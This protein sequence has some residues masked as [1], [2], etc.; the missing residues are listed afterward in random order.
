MARK[1]ELTWNKARSNW[2]RVYKGRQYYLKS[3]CRNKSDDEG[4]RRAL[5][6]WAAVKAHA[7]GNGPE[8][9]CD[10]EWIPNE[11]ELRL[12]EFLSVR[13]RAKQQGMNNGHAPD[14]ATTP[15]M[16][17]D[18]ERYGSKL[19][20]MRRT[21]TGDIEVSEFFRHYLDDRQKKVKSEQRPDGISV[22]Q[23]AQDR[24][25]LNDFEAY[26]KAH[27]R[28]MVSEID[29]YF[30]G[31]YRGEQENLLTHPESEARIS[32]E[33]ARK[34][35]Q[36]ILKVWR[37][38]YKLEYLPQLPR[39]LDADYAKV[40]IERPQ[41]KFWTVEEIRTLFNTASQRTKLYIALA[42]NCGY[43]QREIATLEWEMIDDNVIR[44]ERPKS[45]QP[46]EHILWPLTLELLL[47][48]SKT[49][50]G[51]CL[52]G[53]KG[54]ELLT[55]SIKEDGNVTHVDSIRLAFERTMKKNKLNGTGRTF[56]NIRKTSADAIAE[57]F[58]DDRLVD[59]FLAHSTKGNMR[60]H[61]ARTYSS[62]YFDAI[63]WLD[64]YYKLGA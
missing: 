49:R 53:A 56:K 31:E 9:Y 21:T 37:W 62:Q 55:E 2:K 43:T 1:R 8:P 16:A 51:L 61:Y 11:Y 33:T 15:A 64:T 63:Q 36:T 45:G 22:K 14:S 26:A 42:C 35:L 50:K 23:Y 54:N 59:L 4:Y 39:V 6:E 29:S 40:K 17:T 48:E 24:A 41:P 25:K 52:K 7:D 57:K 28:S 34:R 60:E 58:E 46:Q 19:S 13:Q 12:S 32:G 30:L 47:K 20:P 10:G 18:Y 5:Q 27:G 3:P 44:R 38:G